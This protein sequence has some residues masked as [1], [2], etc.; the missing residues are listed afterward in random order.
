MNSVLQEILATRIVSDGSEDLP[1]HSNI[2]EAEGALIKRVFSAVRPTTSVEVGFAYG[3]STLFICDA[4]AEAGQT[5]RHYVFDPVQRTVWKGI[6]LRNVERAGYN[7]FVELREEKSELGLPQL[8]RE[9][10]VIDAALIDGW[11][12]FDHTL[13]D[14]F[15]INK[16]LRVGGVIIFDDSSWPSVGRVIDHILTYPCYRVFDMV[17][18]AKMPIVGR[19]WPLTARKLA[20]LARIKPSRWPSAVALQK[21][22][23]DERR[24]DWHKRF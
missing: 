6:G 22:A 11:H 4:L 21:I 18:G 5:A 2:P 23:P 8:L 16:M 19:S 9:G 1:L 12:T 20:Y 17:P 14:F 15:Y 10:A 7:R 24:W 13:V 3:I